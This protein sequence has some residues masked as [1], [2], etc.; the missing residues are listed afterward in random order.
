[1]TFW[2]FSLGGTSA[3]WAIKQA[4]LSS[5]YPFTA[6]HS[7]DT[8]KWTECR[9]RRVIRSGNPAQ[10]SRQKENATGGCPTG[11]ACL[12]RTFRLSASLHRWEV[13]DVAF[14]HAASGITV[15]LLVDF[16]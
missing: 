5:N 12:A 3:F 14:T 6:A 2:S 10:A 4:A 8:A 7:P 15:K 13:L 1:V 11:G 16:I 9:K